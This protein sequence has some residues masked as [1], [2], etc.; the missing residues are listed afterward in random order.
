MNNIEKVLKYGYIDESELCGISNVNK[1]YII[2]NW[3]HLKNKHTQKTYFIVPCKSSKSKD[4]LRFHLLK[5]MCEHQPE[6]FEDN[7]MKELN[8]I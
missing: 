3:I 1:Q 7:L 8:I 2:N 4:N 5:L 6:T